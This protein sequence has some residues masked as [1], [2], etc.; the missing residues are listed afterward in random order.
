MTTYAGDISALST[1]P[2]S[3]LITPSGLS[4]SLGSPEAWAT[5]EV[6]DLFDLT[7]QLS[8]TKNTGNQVPAF[9]TDRAG[10]LSNLVS[11][12]PNWYEDVHVL[13]TSLSL[14]NVITDQTVAFEVFN[15]YR[16]Q[17]K[18]FSSLSLNLGSGFSTSGLPSL[19]SSVFKLDTVPFNLLVSA[20]GD[21]NIT[22][23][24]DFLIGGETI[25]VPV[26]G[27]RVV[28][29]PYP[30]E[31]GYTEELEFLTDVIVRKDGTEQR[32]AVRK[33]PRQ[34]FRFKVSRLDGAERQRVSNLLFDWQARVFGVPVWHEPARV[35]SAITAGDSTIT[36]DSTDYADYRAGDLAIILQD[37][38]TF[39]ALEVAST[40]SNTITFS[41][42]TQNSYAVGTQVMPLRLAYTSPS[43]NR[44]RYVQGIEEFDIEFRVTDNDAN[45]ADTSAFS[46]Y[47]S[48]VL[49][50][51]YNVMDG[52]KTSESIRRQIS[53]L[54]S[55]S[56]LF[57]Q[58]SAWDRGKQYWS[59][60]FKPKS[61]QEL[62]EIRQ[63]VHA[64]RGQQVSFYIPTGYVDLTPNQSLTGGGTTM[65]IDNTGYAQYI[66]ARTPNDVIRIVLN[67]G[68]TVTRGIASAASVD[69]DNEQ[70]TVDS[71][72]PG[73]G[74]DLADIVRVEY[75]QKSRMS[76]D[77]VTF[78]HENNAGHAKV[79][80]PIVTVL[81]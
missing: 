31:N 49:L 16:Y 69:D 17:D 77:K 6:I 79:R 36:V 66:N 62:W 64:L 59:K 37:D 12:G 25:S 67:D 47:N 26:T 2:T 63:L 38:T 53:V 21:S 24:M 80:F 10:S 75:I 15:G 73:G 76:S 23:T 32:I 27:S 65:Q 3:E 61:R 39:D 51:G 5:V 71:G 45:L 81:E 35:A 11:I 50:D 68:T 57:S 40:T 43:V 54:D 70:I 22:G 28:M 58:E 13:P 7:A 55:Q 52:R 42:V 60:G 44:S 41:E 78:M 29:F 46:S 74:I 18:T 20:N 9:E 72:W 30:P 48:K 1:A 19:P 33:N 34:T 14:G 8:G 4:S 56:G